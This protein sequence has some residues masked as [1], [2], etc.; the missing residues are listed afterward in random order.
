MTYDGKLLEAVLTAGKAAGVDLIGIG[1]AERFADPALR[2][3]FPEVISVIAIAFRVL[4]GSFRGIEEGTTF[5]QY[6]TTGVETIEEI[7][8]PSALLK[9]SAAIEDAGY[10]AV[11]Q[12]R[13]QKLRKE[14]EKPNPE[15][16][17]TDWYPAGE[18]EPQ[19]DFARAA[20]SCGLGE[21]G[22]SGALLTE[23]F[24]PFQR[25]AFVL[26]DA[27]LPETPRA[28]LHLCDR[29]GKCA[30]AC[31]GRAVDEKNGTDPL[32]CAVY[33]RG[34]GRH[35]NPFMPPD[36]Y[37]DFPDR[38]AIMEGSA[39][40]DYAHACEIMDETYFYPGIKHGYVSGICGRACDRACYD[41]LEKA[42]KLKKCFVHPFR[43]G[44]EWRLE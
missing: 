42:G 11:P 5:Y 9:I 19:L 22:M 40:L 43:D 7:M 38:E 44:E 16:L 18:K 4:R 39:A 10:L 33:Y 15:M 31:P 2:A 28:E 20:A 23:A 32:R 25:T 3:I 21:I 6:T 35:A 27:P 41:H 8:L 34:A 14:K 30:A 13:N 29:C 17:H 24:G 1:G 26:T 12:R 37:A 36:A